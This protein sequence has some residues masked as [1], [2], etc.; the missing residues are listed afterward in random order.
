MLQHFFIQLS[1]F[2]QQ[3]LIRERLRHI[4]LL[5]SYRNQVS[6]IVANLSKKYCEIA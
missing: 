2:F 4:Q 3:T 5:S 1:H 6:A